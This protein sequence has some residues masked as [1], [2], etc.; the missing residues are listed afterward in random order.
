MENIESIVKSE[1]DFIIGIWKWYRGWLEKMPLDDNGWK[2]MLDE[3]NRMAK[4]KEG[5]EQ[6][7]VVRILNDFCDKVQYYDE[8]IRR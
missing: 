6:Q 7:I 5:K 8:L 2:K 4:A 1:Y 3:A